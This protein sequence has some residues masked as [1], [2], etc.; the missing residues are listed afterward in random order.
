MTFSVVVYNFKLPIPLYAQVTEETVNYFSWSRNFMIYIERKVLSPSL[1]GPFLGSILSHHNPF[2]TFTEF[3]IHPT[4]R[5]PKQTCLCA[6][7]LKEFCRHFSMP[8]ACHTSRAF[9]SLWFATEYARVNVS[10]FLLLWH[11]VYGPSPTAVTFLA[12]TRV[13]A[14]TTLVWGADIQN[15]S[16]L[17]SEIFLT[18]RV[19]QILNMWTP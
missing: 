7:F 15:S 1:Q 18:F 5:T 13:S 9:R 16:V 8:Y 3:Y 4:W 2:H 11:S 19:S 12:V 6:V 14:Q 10:F 17:V